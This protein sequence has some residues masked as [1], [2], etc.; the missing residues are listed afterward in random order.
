MPR[1]SSTS[2]ACIWPPRRIWSLRRPAAPRLG[3]RG[4]RLGRG[5]LPLLVPCA[6]PVGVV[7]GLAAPQPLVACR[8]IIARRDLVLGTFVHLLTELF[9]VLAHPLRLGGNLP[10]LRL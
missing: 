6:E 7:P 3:W 10:R 8:R 5:L 9:V 1:A 4:R 2:P